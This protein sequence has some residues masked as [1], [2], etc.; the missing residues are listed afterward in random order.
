MSWETTRCTWSGLCER[1]SRAF[2]AGG[3]RGREGRRERGQEGE[4]E[5]EGRKGRRESGSGEWG[6]RTN[7]CKT[8]SDVSVHSISDNERTITMKLVTGMLP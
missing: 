8:F 6:K 7:S 3:K 5:V 2:A 4:W 1:E